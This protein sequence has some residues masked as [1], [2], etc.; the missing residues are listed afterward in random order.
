M[1]DFFACSFGNSSLWHNYSTFRITGCFSLV[2]DA[3]AS[4][5]VILSY[6]SKVLSFKDNFSFESPD[7]FWLQRMMILWNFHQKISLN[8]DV[9]FDLLWFSAPFIQLC[10]RFVFVSKHN[11]INYFEPNY[12]TIIHTFWQQLHI[13][14]MYFF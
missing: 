14:V 1:K 11:L 9:L 4:N 2:Y 7:Y 6:S 3:S 10:T 13:L 5:S 12:F 8:F